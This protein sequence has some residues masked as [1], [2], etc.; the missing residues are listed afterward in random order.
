MVM[1]GPSWPCSVTCRYFAMGAAFGL[2][3]PVASI[4]MLIVSDALA[5]S[6]SLLDLVAAA[7]GQAPLLYV[8]DMAPLFLGLF[9]GF[10]GVRQGRLILLNE[11]LEQQ[12]AAKTASLR[13]ALQH[14][15]KTN[16]MISHMADHDA[17]TGL[18]NRRRMLNELAAALAHARRHGG[19]FALVF[20]DLNCFKAINDGHGHD[21][22]DRFLTGFAGLLEQVARETD[23]VG[24]WGGDEF[25]VLLPQSTRVQAGQFAD[26]L[27]ERLHSQ[28]ID[29]GSQRVRASVS[30][31][32]AAYPTDGAD[33]EALLARADAQMY[34][35][36][37]A[38]R[39]GVAAI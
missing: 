37:R 34:Q 38:R 13:L 21:V 20:M 30:V 8:I 14:A 32:I 17:L 23:V 16:A 24:R 39:E 35:I 22:G 10:A 15:E 25:V 9:S 3:F 18:L 26:R 36:K 33:P 31:G 11:S 7:H 6:G 29:I 12:V 2:L 1:G 4:G 27:I 19:P 28:P 5:A